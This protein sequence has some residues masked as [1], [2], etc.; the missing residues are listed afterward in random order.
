MAEIQLKGGEIALVDDEDYPLLSRYKWQR[1]GAA[2]YVVTTMQTITGK[3]HTI[4]MHKLIMGGFWMVDHKDG[5]V[6]DCRKQNIRR[7]TRQEN[8]FNTR[9]VP[10]RKG[11][12]T[13]SKYKGVYFD[14]NAGIWRAQI[15]KSKK[16]Y[17]LGSF[18]NE[19]DAGRAYNKKAV[20]LFGEFAWLNPV[21]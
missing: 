20:E 11:K 14:K 7:A 2:G 5:N 12:P 4:Y 13:T 19:D 9:K 1:A 17:P 8:N 15:V 16:N 21:D 18:R 6:L 3:N 10:L